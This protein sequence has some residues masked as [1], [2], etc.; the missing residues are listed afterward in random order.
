MVTGVLLSAMALIVCC[1]RLLARPAAIVE[2]RAP[3]LVVA[4]PAPARVLRSQFSAA[5]RG[6]RAPPVASA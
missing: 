2:L 6:S 4:G 1:A 5:V 3:A